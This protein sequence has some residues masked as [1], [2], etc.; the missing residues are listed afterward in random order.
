MHFTLSSK[1]TSNA[2][3]GKCMILTSAVCKSGQAVISRWTSASVCLKF[4]RALPLLDPNAFI[5][6]NVLVFACSSNLS[7]IALVTCQSV[8]QYTPHNAVLKPEHAGRSSATQSWQQICLQGFSSSEFMRAA[9]VRGAA[10]TLRVC[11]CSRV[12]HVLVCL[13]EAPAAQNTCFIAMNVFK[14]GGCESMSCLL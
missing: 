9:T 13:Q 5:I 10:A 14:V 7:S 11:C 3:Y 1:C 8:A 4:F 12:I 6:Q 2:L